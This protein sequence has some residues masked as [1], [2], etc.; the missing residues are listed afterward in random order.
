MFDLFQYH[1]FCVN[2]NK[3]TRNQFVINYNIIMRL[4]ILIKKKLKL[5]NYILEKK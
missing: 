5:F 2:Q 1:L 4:I 3:F